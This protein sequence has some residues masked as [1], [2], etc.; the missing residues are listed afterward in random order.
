[1]QSIGTGAYAI[2]HTSISART[3]VLQL[4]PIQSAIQCAGVTQKGLRIPA[5]NVIGTK[6]LFLFNN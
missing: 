6:M 2:M 5:R 3:K 4:D 1:M